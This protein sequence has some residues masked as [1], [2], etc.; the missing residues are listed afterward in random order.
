MKPRLHK[1]FLS[2]ILSYLHIATHTVNHI[3]HS[4][5]VE[6][7]K[8]PKRIAITMLRL[9]NQFCFLYRR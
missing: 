4:L 9:C 7:D 8:F 6:A 1:C 2:G 5:C 3:S